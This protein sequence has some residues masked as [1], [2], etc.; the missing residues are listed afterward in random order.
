MSFQPSHYSGVNTALNN[1]G[2][3][4]ADTQAAAGGS[5]DWAAISQAAAVFGTGLVTTIGQSRALKSQQAHQLEMEEKKADM[6]GLQT[7]AANAQGAA[8]R[9]AATIQGM[10]TTRTLLVVG[11]VVLTIG[12]VAAAIVAVRR[13]EEE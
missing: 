3:S 10:A 4:A 7:Q 13:G 6:Y 2:E 5:T 1:E 9:A 8:S 11:G 12:I